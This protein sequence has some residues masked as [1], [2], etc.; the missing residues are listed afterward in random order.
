[1]GFHNPRMPWSTLEGTLTGRQHLRVVDPLAVDG[2]GGDSPAWSR[3]RQPYQAPA[4]VRAPSR[5]RYAELHCHTN[6]SFLDGASHPE[7]LA[8]EAARLG[9]TGLAVTDHDGFYGVVRFSQAARELGLPTIFGAELSL[10]LTR[11][12]NGE[13]DPEGRHLLALAHGPEGYAR[14]ART[15]SRGQLDGAEK[16]KPAYGDLEDVAA[17]LRDHVLVL[18][19]CRKGS[20]PRA[21]ATDGV[22]AAAYELDRLV[23]LFGRS[24]V[25]VE[26]TAHGDP[27]DDDRNDALSELAGSRRLEVVA[28][29]NVH[30][31]TP[32]RRR[33]A[34]ALAAVRA[35]RSLDDMDGWLPA[36]GTAH[37]RSAAEM[38]RR[39]AAYP[40][41]VANAAMFGD[42]L[43]FDLNLVAPRLPDFDIP[44][45]GHTEMSW[46]RE[47]TMRGARDRYGPPQAHPKAYAQ[48][49]HELKM[50]E[51]LNFPGYFLVVYD[52]VN[53]CRESDIY[54]QGRGSAANS[55]VC[56]ALR[57]TNVDAVAYDLL[58]ERFLAPER[59]GP[60]DIDVDIESDRREEVI[61]YV[62]RRYGREHTAQVAN[63]ISYRPRS[64]VRDMAKAFGFS[65]GQQDAWSKQIDRWG[66]VAA[67][68]NEGVPEQVVAFANEVQ[69]FPRHLGIHSGGM[70]ICDRPI[71]EVC[72]VE[73]G[74][75]PGRTVLQWDK[76]DCAAIE[77]VKFDLLGLGMLSA[78]HYA[79]DMIS[80]D[81]DIGTMRLDDPEV[82]AMLCRADSVG[83]FQ[84]ESR[85]QM[86]TLPRL[87]PDKFYDLVVEVALI[88]P[89]PIQGGSVHPYIRRKNGLE[90]PTVPHPLMANALAKTLGVPLFQEQLMQLAIDVAGFDPTEADQ[91][92]RAMGSKRSVEK[93]ER[94]KARL[95][96]GMAERGITGDLADE[97]F[98]KLSAFANYGFPE[99][100]AMSFAYLVYASSWLKRYHPAAFCAA[101]LNAQPMGFYSPQSLVDDARRHGVEVRRPDINR[102][103]AA[104]VLE[105]TPQTRWGS[106]AGEPPHA[107]GLGGPA[108]RM[109]L[110]S[111]RT[112]GDDL[113]Q[114]IEDER[115]ARGPYRDLADLARRTGCSTAHLEALATAD[116]FAGFGLSRREA[117]WAAGAAAQDKPDRLPGTVTGTTA[118]TLPGMA[119]VDKLVADVWATGLSPDSHPAQFIRAELERAGALP[120]ARLGR[121][122]AGT[123]IRAGGIVTHRQRPA[124]A[125][126]VTFINLEDETG[127]LNVTCSPGLWQRYRR[128][129][130][131]S[132]ALIV[133]GRLEKSEGVLNLVA[134]RLEAVTPPISPASRDFR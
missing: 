49:E 116:A 75:M 3:K 58:F 53:F 118:P 5:D 130:R 48:I 101:L 76:D 71:I 133:R 107:W 36:A 129:A 106:E 108:V 37:L 1:M 47:L 93:M 127:M 15:I 7:E 38:G 89:G 113:A 25:V 30:Y 72:P 23:A 125:G 54:C 68:D 21:L 4:L 104:A 123:R 8:E 57:I 42:D 16:G 132:A 11:P 60:P 119:E 122:E 10:D 67:I 41:A 55:A 121:V 92:R 83:V 66:S 88:R 98:V 51:E 120:I 61:Q 69:N 32:A 13:A 26:L 20:V 34:T 90:E 103:D 112:V 74:R 117:L 78:L 27:Y 77:L 9:L 62:Y 22:D 126:G 28:T 84:V 17:V 70:V 44:E 109:G 12:Q 64:A 95:Y 128:V 110:R 24:N 96:E 43:A 105:S 94:I 134:D 31:A 124:T 80:S 81:L 56:Y 73:W 14:L 86:A 52:I 6:F 79:Y 85:A 18:T 87:K 114:V 2:D 46:L 91:L 131:T 19:G 40:G 39:F 63:V 100:H 82:Y 59:D 115:R 50:I 29:N 33:L 111:V 97:L 102:S 65:P 45:A 35:R 99:S